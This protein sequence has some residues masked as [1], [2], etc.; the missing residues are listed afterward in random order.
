MAPQSLCSLWER[1]GKQMSPEFS[2]KCDVT[3]DVRLFQVLAVAKTYNR[4]DT[5]SHKPSCPFVSSRS[6]HISH[7]PTDVIGYMLPSYPP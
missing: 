2:L 4:I 7:A 6:L 5:T 3:S 1:S